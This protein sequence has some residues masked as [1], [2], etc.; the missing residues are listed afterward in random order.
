MAALSSPDREVSSLNAFVHRSLTFVH[1]S[2]CV[3]CRR[4]DSAGAAHLDLPGRQ[5]VVEAK[6]RSA[7]HQNWSVT[8][9]N[10]MGMDMVA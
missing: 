7:V 10:A 8:G 9:G 5:F 2:F 1:W 4:S 6:G 3:S